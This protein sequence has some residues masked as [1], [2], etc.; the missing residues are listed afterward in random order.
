MYARRAAPA[1]EPLLPDVFPLRVAWL[2]VRQDRAGLKPSSTLLDEFD[3]AEASTTQFTGQVRATR[4]R[5]PLKRPPPLSPR[6]LMS[7]ARVCGRCVPV[8][9][10]LAPS[11]QAMTSGS[12]A[13]SHASR[14]GE[15]DCCHCSRFSQELVLRP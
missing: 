1:V 15:R 7:I 10:A 5:I 11:L 3:L 8:S 13:A 2:A 9:R 4:P 14:G 12:A 6:K